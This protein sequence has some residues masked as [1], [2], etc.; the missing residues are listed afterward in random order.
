MPSTKLSLLDDILAGG[1]V[2][3]RAARRSAEEVDPE[4][5]DESDEPVGLDDHG[6]L[7]SGEAEKASDV[8]LGPAA[9]LRSR[10]RQEGEEGN[11]AE[12]PPAPDNKGGT[13]SSGDAEG[14]KAEPTEAIVLVDQNVELVPTNLDAVVEQIRV[15]WSTLDQGVLILS[16][17]LK[18]ARDLYNEKYHKGRGKKAGNGNQAVMPDFATYMAGQL[19]KEASH[20]NKLICLS[21]MDPVSRGMIEKRPKLRENFSA[22]HALVVEK[23]PEK[24]AEAI[25]AFD[26]G[27]RKSLMAVLKPN[28]PRSPTAE[29]TA[30]PHPSSSASPPS[31]GVSAGHEPDADI[32]KPATESAKA[33]TPPKPRTV[34]VSST[35]EAEQGKRDLAQTVR[36]LATV[37]DE[38]LGLLPRVHVQRVK[39]TIKDFISNFDRHQPPE[40]LDQDMAKVLE[41]LRMEEVGAEKL[42]AILADLPDEEAME[43]VGKSLRE[44]QEKGNSLS[45]EWLSRAQGRIEKSKAKSTLGD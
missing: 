13:A 7:G 10:R 42:L 32:A 12:S 15:V 2:G 36:A 19:G 26:G 23:E 39:V 16:E 29:P 27:G 1:P 11:G 3:L 22:L 21:G 25:K 14:P 30:A 38:L 24:R 4:H 5:S 6:D 44:Y 33:E 43:A 41:V 40:R 31:A 37:Y 35:R 17:K 8:A 28:T 20:I 45:P 18:A 34:L 9:P